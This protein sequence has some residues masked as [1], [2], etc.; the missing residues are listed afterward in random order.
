MD[1]VFWLFIVPLGLLF[2]SAFLGL[3][4]VLIGTVIDL[5]GDR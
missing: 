4:A 1:W 2:W 3:F 5:F